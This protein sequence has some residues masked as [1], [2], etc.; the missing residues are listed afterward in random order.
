[1]SGS[2]GVVLPCQDGAK[3]AVFAAA[4]LGDEAVL[5]LPILGPV[6]LIV[7]A[8]LTT[9]IALH[10]WTQRK[11]SQQEHVK[12]GCT[13]RESCNRTLLRRVLRRFFKGSAS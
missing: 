8:V 2:S 3:G 9:G 4:A 10:G 11:F 12:R 5:V 1:M 7:G 13:P 6:G